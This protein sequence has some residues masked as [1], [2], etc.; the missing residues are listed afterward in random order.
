MSRWKE[1]KHHI[2]YLLKSYN[3]LYHCMTYRDLACFGGTCIYFSLPSESNRAHAY[4][5]CPV[6][7]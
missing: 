6:P 4:E 7:I 1:D 3:L 5:L 2:M